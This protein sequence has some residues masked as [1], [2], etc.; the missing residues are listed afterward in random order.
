MTPAVNKSHAAPIRYADVFWPKIAALAA[1][2]IFAGFQMIVSLHKFNNMEASTMD[3]GAFEQEMWKISH[4]HW[5][6]FSTVF[7]SPA[8]GIDG[9]LWLYPISYG[10]RFM[11]GAVFLF[12]LQAAATG[13]AAWGIYRAA[14]VN[15]L[16]EW[17]ASAVSV[18]FLLYPAIIGGSQFDFH[19]DFIALP[20]LIWAYV[21]YTSGHIRACYLL[22]LFAA[23]SKNVALISIGGWGLGLIVWK[24]RVRDGLITLGA[25]IAFF[26]AEMDWIIPRYFDGG[27]N[28]INDS[29]YAYLG[30]GYLSIAIGLVVH[31]PL[32]VHHLLGEGSYFLWILGPVLGLSLFGSASVPA[33]LSLLVLNALSMFPAQQSIANQY[34]VMLSAWVSLALI[35][36]LVRFRS[37]RPVLL[38]G[39]IVSTILLEAMFVVSNI[40]PMVTVT[41]HTLA[42]VQRAQRQISPSNV[43][44]TQDRLGAWMYSF[45][46]LGVARED[47][48]GRSLDMLN[49]LWNESGHGSNVPTDLVA[50][51]PLTPYFADVMSRALQ[52]GY[53]ISFHDGPVFIVSGTHRFRVPKPGPLAEGW[54]P[55]PG[56][57]RIPAWTQKIVL[58]K[59]DWATQAVSVPARAHGEII[60]PVIVALAPGTYRIEVDVHTPSSP[61]HARL[62][63]LM[64]GH[65]QIGIYNNTTK[66]AMTVVMSTQRIISMILTTSGRGAFTLKSL[67]VR[68]LHHPGRK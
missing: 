51:Q 1:I 54:Q 27:M 62:G 15:H 14:I 2:M 48:V 59:V 39:V 57:W 36:A 29:L 53:H 26:F 8:L 5:W 22:L 12:A 65:H 44:W 42:A 19:P 68:L 33:M 40:V 58:G 6:A 18:A 9:F 7:Q 38:F 24:H 32:I 64:I 20:F 3:L 60:A 21:S 61:S 52:S 31:F 63:T 56:L 25:S 11:G 66:S 30:H 37:K 47:A 34:Q 50:D 35:E 17:Q 46:M 41:H 45:N 4:G 10:F 67:S 43:V 23:L 16:S 13:A 28:R 49:V 55:Q